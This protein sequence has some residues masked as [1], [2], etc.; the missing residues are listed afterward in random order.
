M[1][2]MFFVPGCTE[3]NEPPPQPEMCTMGEL[4]LDVYRELKRLR[5]NSYSLKV[6]V[7]TFAVSGLVLTNA[8]AKYLKKLEL[9]RKRP[10][11]KASRT[12]TV[13]APTVQ[14]RTEHFQMKADI[15]RQERSNVWQG[16]S[17]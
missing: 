7:R 15:P 1:A 5:E 10:P 2:S 6:L 17:L 11:P 8:F 9:P 13:A 3:G 16:F 14:L 4:V 12:G